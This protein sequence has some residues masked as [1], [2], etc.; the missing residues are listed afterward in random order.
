MAS[1]S[2][3][4]LAFGGAVLVAAIAADSLVPVAWQVRT[5]LHWLIEHFV[6]Y[7]AVIMVFCLASQRPFVVAGGVM[8]FAALMEALQGPRPRS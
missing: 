2:P 3:R 5:G 4:W 1:S 6:A 8:V 7:F